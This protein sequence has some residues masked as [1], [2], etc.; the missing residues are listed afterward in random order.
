MCYYNITDIGVIGC[1]ATR[2]VFE[3]WIGG[4][5]LTEIY[6]DKP[7][8]IYLES[9]A[10]GGAVCTPNETNF[11]CLVPVYIFPLT[12]KK[13]VLPKEKKYTPDDYYN[14][15]NWEEFMDKN[16]VVAKN[17]DCVPIIR[18]TFKYS[19]V[20]NNGTYKFIIKGEWSDHSLLP[21][22]NFWA[23]IQF[24]NGN[25]TLC[26]YNND[27]TTEFDCLY[28]EEYD[29]TTIIDQLISGSDQYVYKL[30]DKNGKKDS[31]SYIVLNLTLLLLGLLF[32]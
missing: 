13:V 20:E 23:G 31:A 14:F 22:V 18:N 15:V 12:E 1:N 28:V 19:S 26:V 3:F 8:G 27:T 2:G 21:T 9:P 32:L 7:F 11:T 5:N 4:N 25:G 10:N 17:V 24:K 16:N 29:N 6:P 30:E